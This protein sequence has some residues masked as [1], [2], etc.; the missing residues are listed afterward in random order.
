MMRVR[1]TLVYERLEGNNGIQEDIQ[2][3]VDNFDSQF[4]A[5][6]MGVGYD[7]PAERK[8]EFIKGDDA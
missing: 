7:S 6:Y 5:E 3:A 2:E 4:L 8:V 1:V